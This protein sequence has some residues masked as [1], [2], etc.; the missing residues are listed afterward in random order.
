MASLCTYMLNAEIKTRVKSKNNL[1][2]NKTLLPSIKTKD[3][4]LG[5][6]TLANNGALDEPVRVGLRSVDLSILAG[7]LETLVP[8]QVYKFS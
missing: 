4:Q 7:V 8:A 6:S 5:L 2:I 3:L 1:T